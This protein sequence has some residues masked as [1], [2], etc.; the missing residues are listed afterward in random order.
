MP[1]FDNVSLIIIENLH[2]IDWKYQ[3]ILKFGNFENISSL[4]S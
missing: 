2:S 3:K 4:Q 1:Y